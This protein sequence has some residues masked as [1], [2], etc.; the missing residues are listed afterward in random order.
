MFYLCFFLFPKKIAFSLGLP[1]MWFHDE[2]LS[3]ECETETKF[4]QV[5]CDL[6]DRNKNILNQ[7]PCALLGIFP[8]TKYILKPMNNFESPIIPLAKKSF[9]K[10]N[11]WYKDINDDDFNLF[12]YVDKAIFTFKFYHLENS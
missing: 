6:V 4:I 8:F 7:Q 5:F 11:I 9:N 3:E 10:L 2:I 1:Y 12:D